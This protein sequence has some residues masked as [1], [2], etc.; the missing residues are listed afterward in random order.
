MLRYHKK[1]FIDPLLL[2]RL[3]AFTASLNASDWG[4]SSHA[5]ENVKDRA[6]DLEALL[7]F[8]KGIILEPDTIF[9]FYIDDITKDIIKA[10]YRVEWANMDIILVL[11][12]D[13]KI[14]TI[15][16]NGK[17]DEHFTLNKDLY[18]TK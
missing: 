17:G 6:I 3:K 9:E 2:P 8:I 4:Y 14:I 11:G 12:Q 13:K 5:L 1:V 18:N 16:L 7:R 10:C 15:Y